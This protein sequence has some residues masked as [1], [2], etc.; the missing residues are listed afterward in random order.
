M[1][2]TKTR[3]GAKKRFMYTGTG[4]IKRKQVGMRHNLRKKTTKAK[5]ML[6]KNT[7]VCRAD[8][9]NIDKMLTIMRRSCSEKNNLAYRRVICFHMKSSL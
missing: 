4:K 8:H 6:V 9:P 2:K 7:L 5:R 1:P 3:S